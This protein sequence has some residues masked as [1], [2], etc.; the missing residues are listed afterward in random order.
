MQIS[1]SL[2][3]E[4]KKSL[5]ELRTKFGALAADE[6]TQ[7]FTQYPYPALTDAE[8]GENVINH[9]MFKITN[10]RKLRADGGPRR[11]RTAIQRAIGKLCLLCN[12][13]ILEGEETERHH[14][15]YDGRPTEV[16]H[17]KCHQELQPH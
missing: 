4:L 12:K 11:R 2:R 17:K 7:S 15:F 6:L 8:R 14:P 9:E 3:H 10:Q 16:V 13:V 1:A 5:D